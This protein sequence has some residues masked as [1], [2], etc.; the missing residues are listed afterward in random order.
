MVHLPTII[1]VSIL[2]NVLIGGFLLSLYIL[3]QQ[4]SYLYWGSS[5][6][7]FVVA[8]ITASLRIF[9]DFPLLTHYL[10]DLFI[11]AA[12]LAAILGVHAYNNTDKA[13]LS[14][15]I[16]V[17]ITS[18]FVLIPLYNIQINQI[19]TTFI[20]ACCFSYAAYA[21]RKLQL[22]RIKHA[23]LLQVCFVLHA[24]L[25]FLQFVLLMLNSL[26]WLAIDISQI[27]AVILISHIIITTCTAMI[28]P[29]LMFLES[30]QALTDLANLDPLTGLLNRRAFLN[31]SAKHLEQANN[32]K[33]E[34]CALMIDIDYFK[35]VNDEFGHDAGDEAIKWVAN[36]IQSQLREQ[37]IVARIGGEEFAILLPCT[38]KENGRTLSERVRLAINSEQFI[39]QQQA[40][41]L[42]ISIGIINHTLGSRNINDLLAQADKGLYKAKNNG[43]N[44]VVVMAF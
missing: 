36:K 16:G 15:C 39:Y 10:A 17:L 23:L 7:I 21:L 24:I 3:R 28:W 26:S 43:R 5:C 9:I 14:Y 13:T 41:S 20:I 8:Q 29:L 19:F 2:L 4:S 11:I 44:Q 34:L 35:K 27:L 40:I 32:H 33:K 25:M 42:S 37:D 18:V 31:I 30:E 22:N 38:S 6:L 1:T 12:P